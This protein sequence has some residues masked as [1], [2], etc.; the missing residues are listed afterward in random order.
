[1]RDGNEAGMAIKQLLILTTDCIDKVQAC[2]RYLF[3]PLP[4][5]SSANSAGQGVY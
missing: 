2:L 3:L 5:Q 4:N 1:M